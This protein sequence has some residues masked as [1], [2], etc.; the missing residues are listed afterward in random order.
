MRPH[1][2]RRRQ[3]KKHKTHIRP[4]KS[5]KEPETLFFELKTVSE[6]GENR[7]REANGSLAER[8]TGLWQ[9]RFIRLSRAHRVIRHAS[10]A[11]AIRHFSRFETDLNHLRWDFHINTK[12][13]RN[14]SHFDV[15]TSGQGSL[16]RNKLC[17]DASG[18]LWISNEKS[19]T[20]F[21]AVWRRQP[22]FA[23]CRIHILEYVKPF[24]SIDAI[25][26]EY[27]ESHPS[28]LSAPNDNWRI[29]WEKREWTGAKVYSNK[30][31]TRSSS[32]GHLPK[33]GLPNVEPAAHDNL[34]RLHHTHRLCTWCVQVV[35][36]QYEFIR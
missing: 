5:S 15:V 21:V 12:I 16:W 18:P 27:L 6:A 23:H 30:N 9:C 10:A 34:I 11:H 25:I 24:E 20:F 17:V 29:A 14:F 32:L 3:R 7:F 35:Y 8:D 1:R 31:I 13:H 28:V 2:S 26:F 33:I 22:F 4:I 36:G 19:Q